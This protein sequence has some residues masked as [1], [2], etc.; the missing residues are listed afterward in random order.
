MTKV[1]NEE[2][3][4]LGEGIEECLVVY[5]PQLGYMVALT[6]Q[7]VINK[8]CS[9]NSFAQPD[10]SDV[11]DNEFLNASKLSLEN[12]E[13]M[14]VSEGVAHFKSERTRQLDALLGDTLCDIM[15][16]E[17]RI[18]YELQQKIVAHTSGLFEHVDIC[19][20]LDV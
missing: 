10:N 9:E 6:D 4:E 5:L 8:Y 3:E 2:L 14:F 18:E 7:W 16:M 17:C 11:V 19:A 1:A 13:F 12:Y 15:D 20:E